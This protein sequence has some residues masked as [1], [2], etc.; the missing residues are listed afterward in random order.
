MNFMNQIQKRH[1]SLRQSFGELTLRKK[2]WFAMKK[3]GLMSTEMSRAKFLKL[4][5]NK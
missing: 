2:A 5:E 4:P 1:K 3:R